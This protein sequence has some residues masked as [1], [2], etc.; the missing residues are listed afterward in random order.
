MG[1]SLHVVVLVSPPFHP[2]AVT[3]W[4]VDRVDGEADGSEQTWDRDWCGGD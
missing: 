4:M 3:C 2:P 1:V